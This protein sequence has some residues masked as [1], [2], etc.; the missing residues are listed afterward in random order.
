MPT[1]TCRSGATP[2]VAALTW[3]VLGVGAPAIR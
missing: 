2:A 3:S 1:L